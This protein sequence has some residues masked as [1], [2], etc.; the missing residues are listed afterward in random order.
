MM[1]MMMM[2]MMMMLYV[3][4]RS[5]IDRVHTDV[6]SMPDVREMSGSVFGRCVVVTLTVVVT[7]LFAVDLVH[8]SVPRSSSSSSLAVSTLVIVVKLSARFKQF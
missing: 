6:A 8:S 3:F 2:M 7:T 4:Q 1:K 5:G